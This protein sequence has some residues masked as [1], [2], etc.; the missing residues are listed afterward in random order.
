[1]PAAALSPDVYRDSCPYFA[2]FH[3]VAVGAHFNRPH[4]PVQPTAHLRQATFSNHCRA[5]VVTCNSRNII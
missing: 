3:P 2:G 1:M 4:P 5:P